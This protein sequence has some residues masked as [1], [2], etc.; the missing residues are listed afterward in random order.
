MNMYLAAVFLRAL[1]LETPPGWRGYVVAQ[2]R[3]LG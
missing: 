1:R 3:G 2:G